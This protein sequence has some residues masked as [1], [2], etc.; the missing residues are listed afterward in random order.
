M[1]WSR[2]ESPNADEQT[3]HLA[4][5]RE[6]LRELLDDERVPADV[7]EALAAD[8]RQVAIMLDKLDK[9]QV[10]IAVFGRV[11][12]GKS[13]LLNALLGEKR[14]RTSALHGETKAAELGAWK[15]YRSG[16]VF[17]IDTPGINEVDGEAR[18]RLATETAARADLILF[19]VDSDVTD[20]ELEALHRLSRER[21]PVILV[22]NKADRYT[23]EE[24]ESL[25]DSLRRHTAGQV[26]ADNLIAVSADPAP[27]LIV[28]VDADGHETEMR[29]HPEPAVD[30]LRDRL[31]QIL[32]QEGRTLAALNASL[33]AGDLSDQVAGRVLEAKR[34]LGA[35]L[36]RTYCI[37]KG[38]AVALNPVPVADL[39]AAAAVDISMV[40]HLSRLY[41]LPLS[42]A[43]A[44]GL[45]KT[46]GA[47]MALLMGTVWAIHFVSS[48]L[49][50]G[51]AGVSA[52]VTGGAQGALAYYATYIVGQ[53]A[54]RYLAAGRSWGE[55]GPKVVVRDILDSVDRDS[56]LAQAR[57]DIM[58]RLK[59]KPAQ[60][61][62]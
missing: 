42:R 38:V 22:L 48:A 12:V 30:D 62:A 41:G 47:Q 16:G 19:V 59:R 34:H 37:A 56:V 9:E 3:D 5:A 2:P 31:W 18:E 46:I 20:T 44:G 17:L 21:R 32:E 27:Q 14:F 60:P 58:A 39:L 52:L 57:E 23:D 28:R 45:I 8:Y 49:K 61:T 35:R 51:T 11:S 33:F 50:L 43:E 7:R 54:E 26:D 15:E 36:V 55:G 40:V 4:V 6:N 13:A 1:P 53:A 10:H 24:L 25:L 29:R